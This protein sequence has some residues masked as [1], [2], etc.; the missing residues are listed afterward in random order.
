MKVLVTGA[1]GFLGTNTVFELL[2]QGYQVKG[3]VRNK[4]SASKVSHQN[5]E[6]IEGDIKN[7]LD[8]EKAMKD[9]LFVIHIAA[10][11]DPKLLNYKDYEKVNVIG[12]KNVLKACLNSNIKK[13]IYVSTANVFGFGN[14]TELGKENDQIKNPF[15]K[16]YYSISKLEGQKIVF[17]NSHKMDVVS[18][19]PSFMIGPYDSKPTSGKIILM[20]LK[21]YVVFYPPGGKN[22]VHVKDVS[23]GIISALEKGK[24]GESYLLTNENLTYHQFYRKLLVKTTRNPIL[25]KLPKELLY[26]IGILGDIFRKLGIKTSLSST[27]LS[28]LCIQSY[29]SNDKAKRELNLKFSPIDEALTDAVNWFQ[30]SGKINGT[31]ILK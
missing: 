23:K 25:I 30:N 17:S 15:S 6:L 31:S 9:C 20:G 26:T 4:A 2:K 27:N 28:T 1:N 22:F 24:N 8:L 16:S 12:T 3:L 29:Y 11:T 10:I 14:I 21:K 19:H 13:L 5:I 18:V 7:V